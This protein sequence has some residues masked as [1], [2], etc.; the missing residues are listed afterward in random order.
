MSRDETRLRQEDAEAR[1]RAC[2]IFDRPFV[3]EAGAGT[4]KTAVLV[5]RCLAWLL[6][7]G[8][9][10]ASAGDDAAAPP[11]SIAARA[12]DG[13][14]A[15]T[16][17]EAAAAEM[18][19]RV[20]TA[21]VEVAHGG[22]PLGLAR[23]D[24]PETTSER[25]T[26]LLAA[27]DHLRVQTIHGFCRSLLASHPLEARI[28]PRFAIDADGTAGADV[29]R[30]LLDE[31]LR[32]GYA[33][34][35]AD[36]MA[37]ASEGFGPAEI[38]E[39]LHSFCDV[40]G[41]AA[42]LAAD[43]LGGSRIQD[44]F[45]RVERTFGG[46][47]EAAAS[48]LAT[49]SR[50][51]KGRTV[52]AALIA[53]ARTVADLRA[54]IDGLD[55]LRQLAEGL[56]DVCDLRLGAWRKGDFTQAESA[57]FAETA[58]QIANES[59]T[60]RDLL[61]H[62]TRLA[63]RRLEAGRAVLAPLLAEA[64]ARRRARGIV[65]FDD[66]LRLAVDL[67]SNEPAVCRR[68][69]RSLRQVLVD[70]FQDTDP[71]QCDLL[72]LL[73]LEG[74]A[75]ERPGL[76]LVGDPKQSIY[77][78]RR[79]DLSAYEQFVGRALATAPGGERATL[80]VNFRSLPSV[81]AEVERT[82]GP[83]FAAES[84]V[85]PPFAPLLASAS[86]AAREAPFGAG[87]ASVEHWIS[88]A[89]EGMPA[90]P[91]K[92]RVREA[93]E[94]EAKA[95][96]SD[97]AD[98]QSQAA[99]SPEVPWRW[100]DVALIFRV[101]TAQE[102]YLEALRARGIPFQVESDRVFYQRR[103]VLDATSWIRTVL[104]PGDTLALLST[105]R[106][107]WVGVP[108]AALLPLWAEG[109]PAKIA[110]LERPVPAALDELRA[111]VE[112]AAGKT[113]TVP[114]IERV[115]GWPQL[116]DAACVAIA[117]LRDAYRTQPADRFVAELRRQLPFEAISAAR[118][119]GRF[120]LANLTRWLDRLTEAL[121]ASRGDIDAVL[122]RLRRAVAEGEEDA[123]GAPSSGTDA[124]RI[125]TI[126]KAKGLDFDHVYLPQL[127]HGSAARR[128]SERPFF[129]GGSRPEYTLFGAP[130]LGADGVATRQ[131][132]IAEAERVRLLY[133]AAT[134]ARRRVVLLGA[135]AEN[136]PGDG[137]GS[138]LALIDDE[139]QRRASPRP[140]HDADWHDADGVRWRILGL[141]PA[142]PVPRSEASSPAT[143]ATDPEAV[144]RVFA[145]RR[146]AA[147]ERS[148][149]PLVSGVTAMQEEEF[150]N[151][152]DGPG[153]AASAVARA[154][155]SAVHRFLERL[156]P[157]A[158]PA[159]ERRRL[160]PEIERTLAGELEGRAVDDARSRADELL[161]R[162]LAGGSLLSCL[163]A[164]APSILA[165][166]LPLVVGAPPDSCAGPV[167]AAVGTL[168]L[169]YRDPE[170]GRAVVVDFK[171]DRVVTDG[172]ASERIAHHAPQLRAYGRAVARA[173]ALDRLPRLEL[174]LLEI[175]ARFEVPWEEEEGTWPAPS[176]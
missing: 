112:R 113:P 46:L 167:A 94:I 155:G 149:R 161:D 174:W 170:D 55:T 103:E 64:E 6:G 16:F 15:I 81:L 119:L 60:A 164:I 61:A 43:P 126:H 39:A 50:T 44:L 3:L 79:A 21:L 32:E 63:P 99:A 158:D 26:R 128:G 70:E 71:L 148:R 10:Q 92:T 78:W 23:S 49:V 37:L 38:A 66:L 67:L 120:R 106:S 53:C 80:S 52:A 144:R 42:D 86:N 114:G 150:A 11:E 129:Q 175:D 30:D 48:R 131:S 59:A 100:S 163:R 87:R 98:L 51:D 143:P 5:A 104:D 74:P 28:H 72:G 91:R 20:G 33:A 118:W 166:E 22:A 116:L 138:L 171:T 111:L 13:L 1:R 153:A 9:E 127:H 173:L 18:A 152:E 83:C 27:F 31:R 41:R 108:D 93:D 14:V 139:R 156:D 122:R 76:F 54:G 134:R 88:W 77:G 75:E 107:P 154:A 159:D 2:L 162:F 90:S 95:I 145:A 123:S 136:G 19:E 4:G 137:Q 109:F 115:A 69:R 168:D 73:A 110:D 84:G 142:T 135:D 101:S 40:G 132:R 57:A 172:A 169:L 96:A 36:L 47:G 133:V 147:A 35:A 58:D 29:V 25:A 146:L 62:L 34:G 8:W 85:Q 151:S 102:P 24:L 176:R 56:R 17:T 117:T 82:I 121:I 141:A 89:A 12:L 105:L 125:L 130:T 157:G 65:S 7:P 160:A 165:R 68:V 124:V 97:L 45:T 140:A